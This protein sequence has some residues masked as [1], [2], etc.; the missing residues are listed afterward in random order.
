MRL[1]AT[2]HH[3]NFREVTEST[4][5]RVDG[6]AIEALLTRT[7]Y[8]YNGRADLA[9]IATELTRWG[10]SGWGWVHLDLVTD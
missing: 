8:G 7:A 9:A 3:G 1:V 5:E 6:P 10:S 2:L 4:V